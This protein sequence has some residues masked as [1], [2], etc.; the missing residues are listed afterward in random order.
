MRV[1]ILTNL[2]RFS[3][4]RNG[5]AA[6]EFALVAIPFISIILVSLQTATIFLFD[7]AL[8]TVAQKSARQL[9]TGRAQIANLTQTQ[10]KSAVCA[11]APTFFQCA[12]IM[13]DVES[14]PT[15]SS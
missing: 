15:F 11:N 14:A 10:F 2:R 6:A 12:N 4:N 5:A 13:V 8:Q 1:D 7:G 3:K 9:M